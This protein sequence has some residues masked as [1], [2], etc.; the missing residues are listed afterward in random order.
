MKFALY[1]AKDGTTAGGIE[2]EEHEHKTAHTDTAC[3]VDC[4]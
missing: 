1:P 4:H 3:I 2:Y